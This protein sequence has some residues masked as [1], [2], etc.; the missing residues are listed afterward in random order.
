MPAAQRRKLRGPR[1][2]ADAVVYESHTLWVATVNDSALICIDPRTLRRTLIVQ[3][4]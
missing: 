1:G 2:L 3:I 4:D